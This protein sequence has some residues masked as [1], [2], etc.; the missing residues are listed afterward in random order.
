MEFIKSFR[1]RLKPNR[2]QSLLFNNFAGSTRFVY[3]WALALSV[4]KYEQEKKRL[5]YAD[6]CS[7]L[8]CLKSI[9]DK[10]WLK[11]IHSQVLQQALKDLM[12]AY[13]HFFRRLK[14]NEKAGF[15][16]F[17]KK[18]KK[19]SFRYPQ[20]VKAQNGRVF[21]PNI[22][23]VTYYDSRPLEGLIKQAT[24]KRE[25]KHWFITF[26]CI[27]N[28]AIE[29]K[30][31]EDSNIIGID[32]GLTHFATISN[33]QKIENPRWLRKA[34]QKLAWEQRKLS[35]KIKGSKNRKKQV[36]NV[37]QCHINVK[38]NRKDFQ[39][40]ITTELVKNHDVIVVE[41]LNIK[42]MVK[43]HKLAKSI[44]DASWN[45]FISMLHYKAAWRGKRIITV[46]RYEP[47]T[48]K[49]SSCGRIQEI[50]LSTRIY[51]CVCGLNIDRDLNA[52][53]NIRAAGHAV[54][55]CGG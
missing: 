4:Q 45:S 9:V 33:G 38:N 31:I 41:N 21:L 23:W 36:V 43:N 26:S 5:R 8:T 13:Q 46:G 19:D 52:S 54:L 37:V 49:C 35:R 25:G 24:I 51:K 7:E 39:Q 16:Q 22:G 14:N 20:G 42:G 50:A 40:K 3:N 10:F 1:Y 29:N 47:S 27:I 32:M 44:S 6:L 11:E 30:S 55:A 28:I 15:P 2:Q 18:G 34:E 17:R 12:S 48:K 53:I